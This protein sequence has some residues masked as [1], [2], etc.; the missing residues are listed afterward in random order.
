MIATTDYHHRYRLLTHHSYYPDG[1]KKKIYRLVVGKKSRY[2]FASI[3][4]TKDLDTPDLC[5][6]Y[7][8]TRRYDGDMGP[9]VQDIALRLAPLA[10]DS[11]TMVVIDKGRRKKIKINAFTD[12]LRERLRTS[13]LCIRGC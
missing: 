12:A 4:I 1:A 7:S 11:R 5:L 8:D 3:H 13:N 9:L 2:F 10:Q 6:Y